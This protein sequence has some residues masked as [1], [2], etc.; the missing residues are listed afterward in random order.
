MKKLLLMLLAPLCMIAIPALADWDPGQPYKMHFPQLPDPNGWDVNATATLSLADDWECTESGPVKDIHF[1]G[2][3]RSDDIGVVQAFIISIHSNMPVG[4]NGFSVPDQQIWGPVILY[5]DEFTIRPVDPP[6]PQGW[7]DPETGE[8]FPDEHQQ[9][10]Q[11]NIFLPEYLWFEQ[12]LDEIYWLRIS[13][14]VQDPVNTQWG[15]KSSLHHWNDDAVWAPFPE[16]PIPPEFW[17]ELYEPES[18]SEPIVNAFYVMLDEYGTFMDGVGEDHYGDGWYYYPMYNWWNIWFFDHPLDFTRRKEIY[19]DGF[20]SPVNPGP[21]AYV[22]IAINWSTDL[23]EPGSSPPLPGMFP[24]EEEDL[25][26]GRQTIFA[27]DIFDL[28]PIEGFFEI[29]NYN[30]EWVSIDVRGFNFMF[31]GVIEHTCMPQD[32]GGESLDLAF[33]INGGGEDIPTLNEWG[34]IILG[35]MLLTIGTIAVVRRRKAAITKAA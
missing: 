23:W 32:P 17:E 27:G 29:P 8:A 9:Y 33:V 20:I 30:P 6:S 28:I 11:Y 31:E 14:I 12:T 1:W 2:S 10:F 35:L 18:P 21:P 26:I 3:W 5:E 7:Y 16:E 25:Y 34:M 4:P 13:A 19:V 24:P 15:W 22:E